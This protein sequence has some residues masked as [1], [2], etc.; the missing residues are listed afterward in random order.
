MGTVEDIFSVAARLYTIYFCFLW[1][2]Q[3]NVNLSSHLYSQPY[4]MLWIFSTVL[5]IGYLDD[6]PDG[7]GK[8]RIV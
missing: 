8:S 3:W 4:V 7:L 5:A 6:W 2:D 1:I